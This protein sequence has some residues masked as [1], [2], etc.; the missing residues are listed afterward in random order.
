VSPVELATHV[1]P[2]P[3]T[4]VAT[5]AATSFAVWSS[6]PSGSSTLATN[7]ATAAATAATPYVTGSAAAAS[8][9]AGA[10]AP[11]SAAAAT[12]TTTTA[13][14]AVVA[15]AAAAVV[16]SGKA[17]RSSST[18]ANVP[19]LESA[20]AGSL[21]ATSSKSSAKQ[22]GVSRA[23]AG[24]TASGTDT[25]DDVMSSA[26]RS[27]DG[28]AD[29][30]EEAE[31][32][33]QVSRSRHRRHSASFM[34]P[35]APPVNVP[36][37][38]SATVRNDALEAMISSI[39]AAN[40]SRSS[41]GAAA[42]AVAGPDLPGVA[43]HSTSLNVGATLPSLAADASASDIELERVMDALHVTAALDAEP[44]PLT[45]GGAAAAQGAP[46]RARQTSA[47]S[48]IKLLR[49][50]MPAPSPLANSALV[51]GAASSVSSYDGGS[52][53]PPSPPRARYTPLSPRKLERDE[54]RRIAHMT[55]DEIVV[56]LQ[57]AVRED[58]GSERGEDTSPAS[59][60]S[61]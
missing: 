8:A 33:I 23:R 12:T 43:E 2:T 7:T 10:A 18:R 15:A 19:L 58:D 17:R 36:V 48:S 32:L 31:V 1:S 52:S 44:T 59:Q 34:Q 55:L 57:R 25:D 22:R 5:A 39:T 51:S 56:L 47:P 16:A 9:N 50:M 14:P 42:A 30:A 11:A 29:S 4:G 35:K 38:S 46:T 41:G 24:M 61:R 13:A 6:S 26:Q 27:S 54:V 40:R 28:D 49:P 3:L 21:M 20:V 37:L 60:E 45:V 53:S